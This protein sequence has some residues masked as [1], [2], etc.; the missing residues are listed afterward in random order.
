MADCLSPTGH[1]DL[2]C[3]FEGQLHENIFHYFLCF[4]IVSSAKEHVLHLIR[5]LTTVYAFL[6]SF[7]FTSRECPLHLFSWSRVHRMG[8]LPYELNSVSSSIDERS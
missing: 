2:T 8:G 7:T 3:D 5:G 4:L 1:F 6:F